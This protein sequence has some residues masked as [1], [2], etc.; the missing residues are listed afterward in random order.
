MR[1]DPGSRW[2][3]NFWRARL[4]LFPITRFSPC[5]VTRCH[6][7]SEAWWVRAAGGARQSLRAIRPVPGVCRTPCHR[8]GSPRDGAGS[9]APARETTDQP[10]GF[11][12]HRQHALDAD[13]IDQH[14]GKFPACLGW[15]LADGDPQNLI[16]CDALPGGI[17]NASVP[18]LSNNSR[19][20]RTR[21]SGSM[22][23]SPAPISSA[24]IASVSMPC[25]PVDGDARDG[26]TIGMMPRPVWPG[27]TIAA[28]QNL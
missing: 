13:R 15:R 9:A 20:F 6:E 28:E 23:A 12:T 8:T 18:R 11:A 1:C 21:C 2:Y 26:P 19:A 3:R 4:T 25:V 27:K 5:L 7:A 22:V 10:F 16:E 14:D 24:R 17:C